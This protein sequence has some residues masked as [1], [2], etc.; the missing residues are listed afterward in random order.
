MSGFG[1]NTTTFMRGGIV[2]GGLK[3]EAG[4]WTQLAD[5]SL[6]IPTRLTEIF[7][8]VSD[9]GD[10]SAYLTTVPDVSSGGNIKGTLGNT[11]S[12]AIVNY[13]AIGY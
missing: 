3:I 1:D 8:F 5:T 6:N 4:C 11:G 9:S 13:I 12:G 10:A 7:C 2:A